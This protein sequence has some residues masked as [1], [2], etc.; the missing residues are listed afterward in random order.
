MDL[1]KTRIDATHNYW[2]YNDTLAVSGRIRDRSDDPLLLEVQYIPF[3][4]NNKTILDEKCPPGWSLIWDTCYMYVGAPMTFNE[5]REFCRSDNATMPFIR[6][7]RDILW[8]YLQRQMIHLR[9]PEKIWI[10][11][12]NNLEQCTS[13]IYRTIEIDECDNKRGFVCEI[14]P[15]VGIMKFQIWKNI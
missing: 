6:G 2:N 1:W 13:F 14:D 5:A 3:Q 12:L 4:L 10:Q 7:S 8:L 15:K 11:D 9:Y